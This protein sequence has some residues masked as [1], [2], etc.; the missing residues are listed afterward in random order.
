VAQDDHRRDILLQR[1][2]DHKA[3]KKFFRELL[4]GSRR[5]VD[6]RLVAANATDTM[7]DVLTSC[8]LSVLVSPLDVLPTWTYCT[9]TL[10]PMVGTKIAVA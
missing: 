8:Q 7:S 4:T 6:F 10:P 9:W 2:R 3:A 1:W 5:L